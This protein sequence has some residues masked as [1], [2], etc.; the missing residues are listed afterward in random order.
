MR[1][2]KIENY[3]NK[4]KIVTVN[5][6][7][8]NKVNKSYIIMN[9]KDKLK[10][11]KTVEIIIRKSLEYKQYIAFLK[12]K[13]DMVECAYFHN[14]NNRGRSKISIEIHH[15]PFTLFDLVQIVTDKHIYYDESLNPL[16]IA[17]EVMKLHYQNMVGLLP[18]SV[19]VHQLVHDGKIL[20][21]LQIIFG[22][23]LK[24]IEV[25]DAYINEDL[26]N[27]LRHKLE[28]SK[29]INNLDTTI[30]DTKYVYLEIDGMKLPQL[31]T[32]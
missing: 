25:Y 27:M 18:L 4:Q 22:D 8:V 1:I 26:K 13:I 28:M 12:D 30:L 19:T 6:P 32:K 24:F 10:L 14:V 3:N 29:D 31:V 15:E 11:I 20:V 16:L 9:D 2:P 5:I 17:E 21:P 7:R 23:Y